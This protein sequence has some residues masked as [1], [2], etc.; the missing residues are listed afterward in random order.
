[1]SSM[2]LMH[3][4]DILCP[5]SFNILNQRQDLAFFFFSNVTASTGFSNLTY[6]GRGSNLTL[7]NPNLPLHGHLSLTS[8]PT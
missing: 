2:T 7:A 5:C 6:V 1:M 4:V 3:L 8:D